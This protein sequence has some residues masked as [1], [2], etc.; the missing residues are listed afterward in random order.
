MNYERIT[1]Y[2]KISAKTGGVDRLS[3]VVVSTTTLHKIN[4]KLLQIIT[5]RATQLPSHCI[6]IKRDNVHVILKNNKLYFK[7]I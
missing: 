3:N 7:E 1:K 6:S 5:V 4:T 2:K